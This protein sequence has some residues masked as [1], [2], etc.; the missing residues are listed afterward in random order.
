M[1]QKVDPADDPNNFCW[2]IIDEYSDK[3]VD[4][5]LANPYLLEDGRL[6]NRVVSEVLY[7]NEMEMD[8]I[9]RLSKT[10]PVI[11]CKTLMNSIRRFVWRKTRDPQ[12]ALKKIVLI[13]RDSDCFKEIPIEIESRGNNL[14]HSQCFIYIL[15]AK[16]LDVILSHEH[17]PK[18]DPR[19][20]SKSF[21]DHSQCNIYNE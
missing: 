21:E 2:K 5:M 10:F 8:K 13:L 9:L 6:A 20:D 4:I 11:G 12:H 18:K 15:S 1:A 19:K 16:E 17:E 3:I 7:R 14:S